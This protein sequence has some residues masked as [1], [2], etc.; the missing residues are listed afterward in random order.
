LKIDTQNM[1]VA[2]RTRDAGAPFMPAAATQLRRCRR[3]A[4]VGNQG[5]GKTT[6]AKNLSAQLGLPFM[7]IDWRVSEAEQKAL[8]DH[9]LKQPTW[10]IDGDFGLLQHAEGIIFLDFPR[11]L[12]MWRASTRALKNLPNWELRSLRIWSRLY[13]RTVDLLRFLAVVYRYPDQGRP[14]IVTELDT[15]SRTMPVIRLTSPKQIAALVA[16]LEK[17]RSADSPG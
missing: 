6:L 12:C 1:H 10:I 15:I 9:V 4:I 16:A 8:V 14:R 3:I 11:L 7:D 13:H 2:T 17:A 5:S